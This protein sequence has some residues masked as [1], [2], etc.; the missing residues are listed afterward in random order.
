MLANGVKET[1]TTTGTGTTLTLSAASGFVRFSEAFGVGEHVWYGL[2]SGDGKREWGYGSVGASN[3]FERLLP[4]ATYVSGTYDKTTPSR[5]DLTGTSTL[6][7]VNSAASENVAPPR[8]AN[9][10]GAD[11]RACSL[12]AFNAGGLSG[13]ALTANTIYYFPVFWPGGYPVA[14]IYADVST[15]S[16][17]KYIRLGL[18]EIGE[19]GAPKNLLADS[20]AL[21]VASAAQI[22][23]S[24]GPLV[25]ASGWY[26][27]AMISDGA[28]SVRA[29][30][31]Q[32]DTPFGWVTGVARYKI[33]GHFK[34]LTYGAL[35]NPAD[36]SS[37][38][39][40]TTGSTN[41]I[42]LIWLGE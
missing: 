11:R 27:G 3:T 36:V 38:S 28:P 14:T 18:Y 6:I 37:L 33:C 12:P 30:S 25:L 15:A 21:S 26:V 41:A 7:V 16:S 8:I 32:G 2:Q 35:P 20:G 34:T 42:P 19:D 13:F 5:I 23:A 40:W 22:S 29:T 17:G 4:M 1:T 24:I 31:V 10:G 9:L 39:G